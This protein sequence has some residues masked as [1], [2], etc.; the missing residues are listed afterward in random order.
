MRKKDLILLLCIIAAAVVIA[1]FM[2]LA[3]GANGTEITVSVDGE[4]F[5]TY[6]LFTDKTIDVENEFGHNRIIIKGGSAYMESADCPDKYC[7]TYKPISKA[8][9]NIICLPHRLVVRV[10]GAEGEIDAVTQ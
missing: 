9:E 8:N 1:F 5:G 7:M 10:S 2:R 6:S 4:T 3:G